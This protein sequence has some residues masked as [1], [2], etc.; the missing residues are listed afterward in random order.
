MGKME[1]GAGTKVFLR[2]SGMMMIGRPRDRAPQPAPR[3]AAEAGGK[4][5]PTPAACIEGPK[6]VVGAANTIS[7]SCIFTTQQHG[8]AARPALPLQQMMGRGAHP[9]SREK[10]TV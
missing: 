4:R 9:P 5:K 3:R 6:L 8:G 10:R 1:V 2:D 7:S